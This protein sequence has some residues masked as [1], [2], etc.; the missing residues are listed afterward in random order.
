V[1]SA[2]LIPSFSPSAEHHPY[3]SYGYGRIK[4]PFQLGGVDLE[5]NLEISHERLDFLSCIEALNNTIGSEFR[6]PSFIRGDLAKRPR[7][8]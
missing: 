1:V 6:M 2:R 5:E 3:A 4:Y 8:Y 7:Q